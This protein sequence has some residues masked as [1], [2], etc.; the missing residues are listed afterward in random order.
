MSNDFRLVDS[1]WHKEL[2]NA[3]QLGRSRLRIVCPFI[4]R[5]VAGQFLEYG[6]VQEIQVITRFNLNDFCEGVSDITALRYLLD[7]GA[8]IRGVRNLHSKVYLFGERRVIVTSA[9]LT[10]TALRRNH[11]FGFVADD[12]QIVDCCNEYFNDLWKRAGENLTVQRIEEWNDKLEVHLAGGS[13]PSKRKGLG[14]NGVDAGKVAVSPVLPDL[15]AE[16]PQ[17]FV[18]FFGTNSDRAEYSLP[19]IEEVKRAGCHWACSYSKGKRPRQ[20][21]DGAVMYMGRLVKDPDDIIIFGRAVAMKHKEV[22]DDASHTDKK[23]RDFK[24]KWPHYI[25]VHHAEFIRIF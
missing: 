13:R 18:K 24:N 3:L 5:R 15:V 20:V 9:N 10:D 23:L 16:A 19:I 6:Q 7:N 17:A 21:D 12:S 2:E 11:E 14:D 22:R 4:K 1:G 8:Q 25:R